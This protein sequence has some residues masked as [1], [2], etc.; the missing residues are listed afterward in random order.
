MNMLN[1]LRRRLTALYTVTTG[2]ILTAVILGVLAVG[3]RE[4]E[5]KNLETF[6]NNLL[7]VT[8]RLQLGGTLDCT[9]LARMES[10]GKMIIYV[11]DNGRPLLFRGAWTPL[12]D[13]SLLIERA[14]R[15]AEAEAV[16]PRTKPVSSSLVRSS[17]FTVTGERQDSYYACVLVIPT[18]KGFQ[19]LTL[20]AFK[21]PADAG[22]YRQ[23]FLFIMLDAAGIAALYLVCRLLVG[24]SLKPIEESR[25]KQTEFI[26]AAS[27]ELRAPLSVIRSSLSAIPAAPEK[28][29]QF[30]D[31][32]DRECLRMSDLVGDLLLLAS[33]DAK[34]WSIHSQK[35]DM[36]TLL[37]GV[38]ERFE[39]L[40]LERGV[41]LRLALP[42]NPLPAVCGDPQRLEQV[43]AVLLDNA[44]TYT[45]P[46]K[47]VELAAGVQTGRIPQKGS[48]R[49][50]VSDQGCGISDEDKAHVFDRFYRVDSSRTER[51]H[52]GL[53][54]SIAWELV[55]LH[56]GTLTVGD[57]EG[58]GAVFCIKL[59]V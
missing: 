33:A 8:S 47:Q 26:A 42:E 6:Q 28:Q 35:L 57:A 14:L 7:T 2:F 30:L 48:L 23:R 54:L 1:T 50:T 16:H 32:I 11:E 46:G 21:D 40:Y 31:N 18:A 51:Q 10:G 41:R 15:Q 25:R 19:S 58:G 43:L 59:P 20:L 45:P 56:G 12:T 38:Y 53:G 52:Y 27:H 37:I 5:K 44:L 39:P 13:R 24:R 17:I 34:T 29:Q 4:F 9:W 22:I 3:T 55:R 49:L 36:D